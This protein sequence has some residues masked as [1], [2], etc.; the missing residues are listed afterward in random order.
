MTTKIIV[1]GAAG[2]MGRE[3]IKQAAAD[4]EIEI[5]NGIGSPNS[6]CIG[7]TI[8]N[9]PISDNLEKHLSKEK[10]IIDFSLPQATLSNIRLA[11][12]LKTPI[13]IGTTGID[14]ATQQMIEEAAQE[15]PICQA[16][17][18]SLGINILK[19]AA[20]QIA[21]MLPNYFDIDIIE[22]HHT[23]KKDAPSGTA[24]A[25]EKE[26]KSAS[27]SPVTTHAIRAG[28][29]VGDHKIMF[30]GIGERI[31]LGHQ[32]QSRA[33][34]A[35]GALTVAKLLEEKPIGMYSPLQLL[36]EAF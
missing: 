35:Q 32:A 30:S 5:T 19:E 7:R 11:R 12:K 25:L 24:L 10:V 2:R 34:F 9:V 3:I 23:Q 36:S 21:R 1:V 26:I 31:T 4:Q 13:V 8:D 15:I 18:F 17:N 14:K 6:P 27:E 16:S 28:D 22:A 33:T 20:K 29:I